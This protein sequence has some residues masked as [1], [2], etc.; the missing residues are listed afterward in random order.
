MCINWLW[1]MQR[2]VKGWDEQVSS[3]VTQQNNNT[4]NHS[5]QLKQV[6]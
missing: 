3:K 5:K 2:L 4:K 6:W 1:T